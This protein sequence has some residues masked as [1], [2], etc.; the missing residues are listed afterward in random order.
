MRDLR[1]RVM[2]L[3]SFQLVNIR[4]RSELQNAE[5]EAAER[6]RCLQVQI[7]ERQEHVQDLEQRLRSAQQ[8]IDKQQQKIQILLKSQAEEFQRLQN[9][10]SII[11]NEQIGV[12]TS[13][14]KRIQTSQE[15]PPNSSRPSSRL[16]S[17][18]ESKH[19]STQNSHSSN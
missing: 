7:S 14:G 13:T 4:L 19:S 6:A 17:H 1:Q 18:L 3:E 10:N 15:R 11:L 5:L 8:V 16:S 12:R 9:I 2:S